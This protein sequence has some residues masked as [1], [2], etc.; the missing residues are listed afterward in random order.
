MMLAFLPL[1]LALQGLNWTEEGVWE[2]LF[3]VRVIELILE[4][5]I[6]CTNIL[7]SLRNTCLHAIAACDYY[8]ESV[9]PSYIQYAYA[10]SASMIISYC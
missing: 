4:Y 3:L 8:G 1:Y 5:M 9:L 2:C 7:N 6:Y 10:T